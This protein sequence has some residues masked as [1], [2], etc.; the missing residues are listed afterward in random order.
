MSPSWPRHSDAEI[1]AVANVLRSG[2]TNYLNGGE[3]RT[4]ET[5]FAATMGCEYALT[6]ANGT[7]ALEL[8]LAVAGVESGDE[9]IVTPRTFIASGSAIVRVG[10][11]PVFVDV[12][13]DSQNIDPGKLGPAITG[14]TKAILAVHLAGWPCE[15]D[16]L[17]DLADSHR[18]S[19]IEDCA[20]AHGATYRGQCVGSIGQAGAFSFCADKIISTGG[21]GG[22]L[23]LRDEASWAR[24]WSFRSHGRV[25]AEP[26]PGDGTFRWLHESVGTNWRLTEMQS[27]LGRVQL[28]R[29]PD[30]L[31]RR[32]ENA[33]LLAAACREMPALRVPEPPPHI[34]HAYY[35][36]YCFVRPGLL[37]AGWDR[38]RVVAAL[39]DRGVE[40]GSGSCPEIY[41]ERAFDDSPSRPKTRLPV[42]RTLGE[43]SVAIGVD[44]EKAARDIEDIG[45]ALRQVLQ[46]ATR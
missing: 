37:R 5:E 46:Q 14:R 23:T 10:A 21:E 38:D 25:P 26:D 45:L 43:T 44:H 15:M 7:V 41:L 40:C 17:C 18:L 22:M 31:A 1:D 42:A 11:V 36:F 6:V 8:A 33:R 29:L 4:F 12:D 2:R 24:A 9:V 13:P 28:R 20:Q 19:L 3:G 35:R 27:A 32:R 34:E 39:R 16:Q 30:R